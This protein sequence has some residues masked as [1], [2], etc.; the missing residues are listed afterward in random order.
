M[1]NNVTSALIVDV[2]AVTAHNRTVT[3]PKNVNASFAP[4]TGA[5]VYAD[6]LA[7]SASRVT[8]SP[9]GSKKDRTLP[10]LRETL[11]EPDPAEPS[12]IVLELDEL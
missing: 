10:E 11:V 12:Q 2:P 6:F 8:P 7:L 1:A 4:I 3:R 5:A 9:V